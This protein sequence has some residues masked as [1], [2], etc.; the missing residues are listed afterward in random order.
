MIR[1]PLPYKIGESTH[2]GNADEKLRCEAATYAWLQSH[3]PSIPIPHLWGF[4]FPSGPSFTVLD[5]APLL[6]RLGW[7]FRRS[8]SQVLGRPAPSNYVVHPHRQKFP[9]GYLLMDYLQDGRMLSETWGSLHED[10]NKRMTLFRDVSRI[11]LSLAQV[12]LP[13]IGSLTMDNDGVVTLTN[14]PLTLDL[15]QLENQGIRTSIPRDLTYVTSDTYLLDRLA[16]HDD[17]IRHKL[18]TILGYADG[19]SQLSALTMMRA[20]LPHFI[21]RDP[22]RRSFILMLTD[23]H[24][25]NIFVDH[26]WH[27]TCL[28]DLEWAC[29]QPTE[30]LHPPYWLTNRAVDEITDEDLVAYEERHKEFMS[31]FGEEEKGRGSDTRYADAMRTGWNTGGFWYFNA[32]ES[33]SGLYNLFIQHI[34]PKYGT[35]GVKDWNEFDRLV[36]PYRAPDSSE[37]ISGKVKEREDYLEQIREVFRSQHATD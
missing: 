29:S 6:S 14:R 23:L 10:L 11:V 1:F 27:V 19:Q 8:I 17:R 9:S 4:G 24:P 2:P 32:I 3:C 7:Y 36:A 22:R 12:Q 5:R 18:N 35:I 21:E 37:F 16:C 28:I 34:Q 30:M 33:L 25:S 13:R 20:L 31:A 15:H 26:D